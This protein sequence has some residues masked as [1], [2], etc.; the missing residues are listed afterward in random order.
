MAKQA[1]PK[2][3]IS[4]FDIEWDLAQG[5]N[6]WAGTPTLS[7]WIPTTVAGL[8]AGFHNMVG[9]E[10]FNL[11]MQ[12]GGQNSVEGDWAIVSS[13]PTLEEGFE[14][15]TSIAWPAGWG[16]WTLVSLDR[17]ERV[18]VYRTT[19][20]WEGLYQRTLGV[21][22][23][24]GMMAGKLAGITSRIFGV[25]CWAEQTAMAATGSEYDEFVVRPSEL[26]PDQ[27]LDEL[28]QAGKASNADLAVA[29]DKLK[30]E[31]QLHERTAQ[32]LREKLQVIQRQEEALRSLSVPIVQVWDGVL[33]LPLIGALDSQRAADMMERLL[34][35]IVTARA[36]YAILD[37]TAV[38][39]V[40]TNTAQ[41][42]V[43]IVRAIELL[44]ARAI[45]TGISPAIAQ[46]MV[47]LGVDLTRITTLRNLQEALKACMRWLE[48][49]KSTKA[50]SAMD[51]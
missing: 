37:L 22:W 15:M 50:A 6:L 39:V 17:E 10:R 21:A 28:L 32:E 45:I 13:A 30:R 14:R 11:C 23:G 2:I 26:T 48:D 8:M 42:L 35:E 44:G 1:N 40:D 33:T 51:L 24:S 29:M 46:T 20:S 36:R 18:A 49:D 3:T 27:R 9:T 31:V 19:N 34:A 12:V 25:P 5:I 43:R 4:G 7:M 41:H 16:R 38:A 47:S